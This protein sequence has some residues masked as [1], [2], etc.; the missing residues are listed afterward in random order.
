[1]PR[2]GEFCERSGPAKI[3]AAW[4]ASLGVPVA[5]SAAFEREGEGGDGPIAEEAFGPMVIAAPTAGGT[6]TTP[7]SSATTESNPAASRPLRMTSAVAPDRPVA[8]SIR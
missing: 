7:G 3:C 2:A 6:G 5:R 8:T 1:M 4:A